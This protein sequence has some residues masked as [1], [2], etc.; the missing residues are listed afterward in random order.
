MITN[1][2][3]QLSI[4]F[5]LEIAIFLEN[6]VYWLRL[7][8]AKDNPEHRNFHEGRFWSYNS[9]PELAKLF[10][11][12][13]AKTIR[14]IISRCVKHDLVVVGNFNKKRYDQTNWYSLNDKALEY[15]PSSASR[16]IAASSGES[17]TSGSDLYMPAQTGRPP[18][19]T[20][21]P[22]PKELNSLSNINITTNSE[23]VD[24]P[25]TA[26]KVKKKP[27]IELMELIDVYRGIFPNN[28]QP[29]NRVIS[30]S[31]QKTLSTL[32]KR[33]HEL[34]PEGKPL[35]VQAFRRYLHLL[36]DTAP[37]FS[38]G[39]YTTLDGNRKK[40]GLETFARWNTIV[41]FLE[42]QYS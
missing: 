19:Q 27:S 26:T 22:I 15:F 9:Y 12:W 18:A 14:T 33:W 30:T 4:D 31:L 32:I 3:E 35:T 29:H 6:L 25:V 37:R 28:P 36:H 24:S 38:L 40:N 2:S 7:N 16:L 11:C 41:K 34:D 1:F 10:P 17:T 5:D 42:N 39:E 20:G 8:S 13:T 21:R 23:S